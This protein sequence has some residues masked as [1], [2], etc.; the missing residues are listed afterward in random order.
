M[1]SAASPPLRGRFATVDEAMDA[2]ADQFGDREAYVDG[3]RRCT[4]GEWIAAADTAAADLVAAGVRPGDVVAITLPPSLDYA[5]AYAAVVRAGAVATGLNTR[6]G[7][8]EVDAI[9]ERSQPAVVISE[10]PVGDA[11]SGLGDRR[12]RRSPDD[13]AV[14]IWTSGTT[15]RPKG[16]WFDHRGLEA[17]VATAGVMA[18]PF[19]RRLVATPFAHAGYMAKLWEQLAW[20]ITVVI[21][22]Q[23]WSVDEM[24]RLL[25]SERITVVGGVP[26]QWAKVVD[27]PAVATAD[28]SSLRLCLSATAPAP[29][30]L[31][32]RMRERLGCSVVVRYAMTE[33]PS[34]TGTEPGDAPE[35]LYRSVG[36]PQRGVEVELRDD[37]GR[38]V[39]DGD[40]GRVHVRSACAMRGYWRDETSTAEAFTGDG[41]LRSTDLGRLDRDGNLV[42]VGRVS[43]MYIRG[44]Y[45]VHPL[46]VEHVLAEHPAVAE[47][48]VVGVPAPV[49]GEKGVAFVVPA[50][51]AAPPS[52]VEL[53]SWCGERLA[54]YKAPDDVV[55]VDAL[56]V[57]SMM[58][59]DKAALAATALARDARLG[60][61]RSPGQVDAGWDIRPK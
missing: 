28:L 9:V 46:E 17:A 42:L 55:I 52:V 39:A 43:D 47:V 13:P 24:V 23:P 32:K 18:A 33:S 51:G 27:H 49:I 11:R 6:L 35:V 34:I 31:V 16:A 25:E 7:P 29:P 48:S 36:R 58:K 61:V 37:E 50:A 2:A 44:G 4:F 5:I 14:I 60:T 10:P 19:D 40:V 54:D 22:P 21:T 41:W 57:T 1:T 15:G 53:R 45:N 20:G 12:P 59:V 26:T 30:E 8:R 3:D 38:A 56:P